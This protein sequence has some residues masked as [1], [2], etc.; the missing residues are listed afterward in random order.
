MHGLRVLTVLSAGLVLIVAAAA[1]AKVAPIFALASQKSHP[2]KIKTFGYLLGGVENGRYVSDEKLAETMKEPQ[3]YTFYGFLTG[4][5]GAGTLGELRPD[6]VCP[7][8]L[9]VRLPT[10]FT[11]DLAVGAA[12][13]WPVVPR[14]AKRLLRYS[15]A[16]RRAVADTLKKLGL[17][18]SD[19]VIKEAFRVDLDGNGTD[20]IVLTAEKIYRIDWSLAGLRSY[21]FVLIRQRAGAKW[22]NIL[23]HETYRKKK[24]D[25]FWGEYSV[26]SIGDLDGDGRM[27]LVVGIGGWEEAWIKTFAYRDGKVTEIWELAHYCGV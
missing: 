21:S 6:D 3:T 16:D 12:A 1:Q 13:G 26:W 7:E 4:Q 2:D 5:T 22:R 10:A 14:V 25:V 15:A 24:D 11:A 20:E 23:V 27:E 17:R 8:N 18:K 19:V 9:D